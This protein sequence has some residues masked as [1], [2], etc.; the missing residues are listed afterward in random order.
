[1]SAPSGV[2]RD[3]LERPL[4]DLRIS[5]TDRCN[6]RCVYCMPREKFGADHSYLPRSDLLTFDEI[7]RVAR[8]G[9]RLGIR[10]IRLTGGEPLLR[11]GIADLI[12]ELRINPDLDIAMTTNGALLGAHAVSLKA[13]GLDRVTVSLDS[14]NPVVF[15]Q[16]S[17]TRIPLSRVL[18][19]IAAAAEAGLG[20]VKLNAVVRRE[21]NGGHDHL[22]ALAD[23]F[24]GTDTTVR[25]IEYMDVGT[26]NGWNLGEVVPARIIVDTISAVFP[27]ALVPPRYPGEV[28]A[29]YRYRDGMGEIGVISSVTNP[30]C[31]SCTRAR[32]S[33]DGQVHTCLFSSGGFDLRSHLRSGASD[34]ELEAILRR[35]WL[36]RKDRYS[37]LRSAATDSVT[38]NK[39]EMSYIGG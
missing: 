28:A 10:K 23:H 32:L 26:T 33:A 8:V 4:H 30:F 1:M 12:A 11:A 24:R 29:R 39:I 14:I 20:P 25:F 9:G 16:M 5:V 15:E 3:T 19:G 17:D 13:A 36:G 34:L 37:E 2:V 6:F 18:A 22:L 21:I 38:T 31:R 27:L 35:L 7:A